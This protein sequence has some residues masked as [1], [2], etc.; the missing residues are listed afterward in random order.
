M[1]DAFETEFVR[2]LRDLALSYPGVNEGDSC[3]N[4]AFKAGTK[5]FLYLGEKPDTYR[6]MVKLEKSL[7]DAIKLSERD[8]DHYAVGT[9]R[10]VTIVL[11]HG[12]QPPPGQLESWIDESYRLQA[13]K[14]LLARID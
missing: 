1:A 3:V 6:V 5:G 13:G 4:R 2:S 8:P 12:Q 14:K 10:W 7:D 9:T 11:P